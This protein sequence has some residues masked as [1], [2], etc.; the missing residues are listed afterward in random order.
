MASA[1]DRSEH[2]LVVDDVTER[3]AAV[4]SD[5]VVAPIALRRMPTVQHLA[6]EVS[7][8]TRDDIPVLEIVDRLHPTPAVGGT[9]RDQALAYIDKVEGIDRGWYSGGIGWFE[10]NGNGEVAVALRCALIRGDHALVFAG[11]GIVADSDPAAELAETR[12]KLRPLL[13][14]LTA[15]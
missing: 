10:A 2:R 14:L 15:P 3:L 6:T 4:A 9:P 12:L 8:A 13:E 5:V 7:A 1:K 11:N